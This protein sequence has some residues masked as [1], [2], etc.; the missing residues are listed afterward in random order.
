MTIVHKNYMFS[1]KPIIYAVD[2]G[3]KPV[4]EAKCGISVEPEN[5]KA[6]AEGILKL[7]NLPKEH[8]MRKGASGKNFVLEHHT[9][10]KIADMFER[11][12]EE[13]HESAIPQAVHR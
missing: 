9:Y 3:N 4:D 1:G 5:P 2:S 10:E 13:L 7:Y 12:L 11:L 6:I 8:L